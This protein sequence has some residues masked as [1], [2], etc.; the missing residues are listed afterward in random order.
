[1][2]ISLPVISAADLTC[3]AVSPTALWA[4]AS[5]SLGLTAC[6]DGFSDLASI[7]DFA[8]AF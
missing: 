2:V 5:A 4:A 6:S 3:A 7:G 1:L 8:A